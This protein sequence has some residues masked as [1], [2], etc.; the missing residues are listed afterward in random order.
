MNGKKEKTLPDSSFSCSPSLVWLSFLMI[1]FFV[2]CQTKEYLKIISLRLV[3]SRKFHME[4]GGL[5]LD[6]TCLY[7]HF[8]GLLVTESLKWKDKRR[9]VTR[10]CPRFKD[11]G[12]LSLILIILEPW[13]SR[14]IFDNIFFNVKGKGKWNTIIL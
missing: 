4:V 12:L 1:F 2:H 10:I 6:W 3:F 9:S 13:E 14:I 5:R 8:L 11:P 7:S